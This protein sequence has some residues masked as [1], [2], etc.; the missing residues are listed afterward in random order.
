MPECFLPSDMICAYII[1]PIDSDQVFYVLMGVVQEIVQ[2]REH[3]S[4][5]LHFWNT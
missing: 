1:I 4:S 2:A 3:S 5:P